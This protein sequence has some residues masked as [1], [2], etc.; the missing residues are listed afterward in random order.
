MTP[1]TQTDPPDG[2]SPAATAPGGCGF[3]V[4]GCLTAAVVLFVLL[5]LAMMAIAALRPWPQPVW[6]PGR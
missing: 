4:T 6:I 5:F 3:G 2:E 1:L